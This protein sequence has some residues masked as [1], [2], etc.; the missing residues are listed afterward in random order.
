MDENN[1]NTKWSGLFS[2]NCNASSKVPLSYLPPMLI[3]GKR[4]VTLV[5]DDVEDYTKQWTNV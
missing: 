3:D 4:M 1:K 5:S 2:N